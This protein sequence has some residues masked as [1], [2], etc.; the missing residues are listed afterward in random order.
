[1]GT[2]PS[3]DELEHA[4]IACLESGLGELHHSRIRL[5]PADESNIARTKGVQKFQEH[6][7]KVLSVFDKLYTDTEAGS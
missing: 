5:Y 1:M 4:L 6:D 2:K 7:S 3:Y